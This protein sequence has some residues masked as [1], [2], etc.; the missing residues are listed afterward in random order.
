MPPIGR[1]R[2]DQTYVQ[3]LARWIESL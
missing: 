1:N 2:V 3:V